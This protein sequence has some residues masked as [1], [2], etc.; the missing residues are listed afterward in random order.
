MLSDIQA[1]N[2]QIEEVNSNPYFINR[3]NHCSTLNNKFPNFLTVDFFEIGDC[4]D[5]VNSLNQVAESGLKDQGR[6]NNIYPNPSQGKI[7]I[8]IENF[9]SPPTVNMFN[10]I[11]EEINQGVQIIKSN[12]KIILECSSLENGLYFLLVNDFSTPIIL[13][14]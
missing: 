7:K 9:N 2:L 8:D 6:L 13:V 4:I 12:N 10:I 5:V 11:G 14:D 3:V 1:Y